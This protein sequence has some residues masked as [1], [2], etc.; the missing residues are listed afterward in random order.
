VLSLR[1]SLHRK[2]AE[3]PAFYAVYAGL[4][5]IAAALVAIPG[6]PLGLLTSAVQMLA[7][8][9]L[10][11]A[12]VFLLLLS[13]DRAVLGPWT[14]TRWTNVF[15]GIVIG[16]LVMLSL[17]LSASVLFPA[18]G[19]AQILG[20]LLAGATLALAAGVWMALLRPENSRAEFDRSGRSTWRM[21]PLCDLAPMRLGALSR[22]WLIALRAYLVLAV[23]LVI[24]RVVQI[25]LRVT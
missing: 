25:A 14:N 11:S 13:N 3:A 22:G 9:L 23:A 15:T 18:L 6:T 7:G 5:A 21:P 16:V 2:P 8:V 1:H 4:V 19:G 12:T 20:I 10:P 17:I 24:V